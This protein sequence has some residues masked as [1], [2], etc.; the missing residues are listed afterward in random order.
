MSMAN[1]TLAV[2]IKYYYYYSKTKNLM[3]LKNYNDFG[4]IK[5]NQ[6]KFL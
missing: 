3:F 6:I 4:K 1:L 2:F 5:F